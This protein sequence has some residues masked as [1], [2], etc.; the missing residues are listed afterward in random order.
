MFDWKRQYFNYLENTHLQNIP[1]ITNSGAQSKAAP[2]TSRGEETSAPAKTAAGAEK[3]GKKGG[4][5][6]G[7]QAT[8][9][10]ESGTD[11][12][13]DDQIDSGG[14][15]FLDLNNVDLNFYNDLLGGV[16]S[17]CVSVELLLHSLLEQVAATTTSAEDSGEDKSKN[18]L[19]ED[20]LDASLAEHLSGLFLKLALS[21]EEKK[22]SGKILWNIK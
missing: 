2:L 9:R 17:E 18:G 15:G 4:A 3:P 8:P 11:G 20:G 10:K 12:A 22:V 13:G 14:S 1:E 16:P 21:D 19:K 6:Q 5:G 7:E